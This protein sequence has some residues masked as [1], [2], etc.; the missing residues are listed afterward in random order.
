MS[1]TQFSLLFP[2]EMAEQHIVNELPLGCASS[3]NGINFY[4]NLD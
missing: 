4:L 2:D 3:N 1:K